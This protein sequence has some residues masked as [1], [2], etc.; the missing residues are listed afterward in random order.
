MS[1]L[2]QLSLTGMLQAIEHG[3]CSA[4]DIWQSCRLQIKRHDPVVRSW[5]ELAVPISESEGVNAPLRGLPLG[6]KDTID[7]LGLRAERGSQIWQGRQPRTDAACI[8]SL[9]QLGARVMGKTV[10]TEFAY[11][12]PGATAN[13]HQLFHTPGG[14]SSGSAAAVAA[15]MVPVALGSQTAA[16]VIR[17][18]AYCGVVGYVATAGSTSLRGIMPLAH[19]LDALGFL[20]RDVADL[21]LMQGLLTRTAM[22]PGHVRR[23]PRAVL[24][25][26]GT[27]FGTVDPDMLAVHERA[28]E[29]LVTHGVQVDRY[30]DELLG[31]DGGEAWI[32]WHRQLMACEAAQTL[33]FE[34]SNHQDLL[35]P[36]LQA[37]IEEGLTISGSQYYALKRCRDI[38]L[39]RYIQLMTRYDAVLAP[40][41]PG[42]APKGL[43]T[44]GKPDQSRAWQLLG[45]PQVTLPAGWNEY[46]LPLG[47]QVVGSPC[48]DQ[49]L[50]QMSRWL[51]DELGW[52]GRIPTAFC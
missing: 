32:T 48:N 40:A 18:A 8:S 20:A 6:V 25:L 7:V 52:S 2:Y 49:Q 51:Q 27:A 37:L 26:D 5:L 4:E 28:I 50:L 47:L 44:T 35:S 29:V 43:E 15:G 22:A 30:S 31:P 38:A 45:V 1:A 41:A 46:G 13:P 36:N 3:D 33:A 10:T 34:Y 23:K 39:Q 14:S 21:Q 19:T 16:S 12:T 24:A 9:K 17:P 11:F 42:A